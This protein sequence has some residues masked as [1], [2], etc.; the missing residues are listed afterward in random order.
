M[1]SGLILKTGS[2]Q[3]QI[4]TPLNECGMRQ[5]RAAGQT[6]KDITF[7]QVYSSDLKRANKTCQL[8]MEE[9]QNS[10][11]TSEDIIKD[12]LIEER[13][14]RTQAF[15]SKTATGGGGRGFVDSWVF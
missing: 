7:H 13:M 4:D 2:I 11:I 14:F 3:G 1:G 10:T 8:I 12:E 15:C 9:N 6:L 5:A